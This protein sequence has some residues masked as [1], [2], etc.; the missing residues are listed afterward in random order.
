[1]SQLSLFPPND[2]IHRLCADASSGVYH[3]QMQAELALGEL[4]RVTPISEEAE[5]YVIPED[6][7]MI[8]ADEALII[9]I[10]KYKTEFEFA[11]P[12]ELVE[13]RD[14]QNAFLALWRYF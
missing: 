12:K 11:T 6:N 1:M 2:S 5:D 3:L 8:L 4:F 14:N 10:E 13:M 7:C 9:L